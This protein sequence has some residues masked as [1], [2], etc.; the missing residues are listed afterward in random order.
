MCRIPD[1][2]PTIGTP[3]AARITMRERVFAI[4]PAAREG[5][6]VFGEFNPPAWQGGIERTT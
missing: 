6:D 5:W 1:N 3:I 2:L 4:P